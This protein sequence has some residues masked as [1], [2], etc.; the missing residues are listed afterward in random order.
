MVGNNFLAI[1]GIIINVIIIGF[2]A[3]CH[4]NYDPFLGKQAYLVGAA[5]VS[6]GSERQIFTRIEI[7]ILRVNHL[8][9]AFRPPFLE[10]FASESCS[11]NA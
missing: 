8:L 3:D 4:D 11:A 9:S 2:K 10:R 1:T 7:N 5:G 6:C